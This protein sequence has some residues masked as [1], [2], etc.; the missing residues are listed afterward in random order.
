MNLGGTSNTSS[1]VCSWT[2]L[3]LSFG[4]FWL[5]RR[6]LYTNNHAK[7]Q[8][9]EVEA[10]CLILKPSTKSPPPHLH[11]AFCCNNSITK[12]SIMSWLLIRIYSLFW[13]SGDP[14]HAL[15][16]GCPKTGHHFDAH[17]HSAYKK[18]FSWMFTCIF[19]PPREPLLPAQE[20]ESPS[21][22]FWTRCDLWTF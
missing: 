7:K 8:R 1:T 6:P 20:R 13:T 18:E 5:Y 9:Q 15:K 2:W 22:A 3:M 17:W 11:W 16:L 21:V 12:G 19:S 14:L 4:Q 10:W